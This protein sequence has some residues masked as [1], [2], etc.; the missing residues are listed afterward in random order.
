MMERVL[1]LLLAFSAQFSLG[2]LQDFRGEGKMVFLPQLSGWEAA[3]PPAPLFHRPC[4]QP[5]QLTFTLTHQYI[6]YHKMQERGQGKAGRGM[7]GS[8]LT[9]SCSNTGRSS[10]IKQPPPVRENAP[11]NRSVL[12]DPPRVQPIVQLVDMTLGK[13]AFLL[14]ANDK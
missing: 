4:H 1:M 14:W 10:K 8:L 5:Q 2:P 13:Q 12:T 6:C 7:A 9:F 11:L 3:A